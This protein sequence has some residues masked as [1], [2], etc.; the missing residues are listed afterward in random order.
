MEPEV[1]QRTIFANG[2]IGCQFCKKAC[3]PFRGAI[4]HHELKCRDNAEKIVPQR[5]KPKREGVDTQE[6]DF[7]SLF[8]FLA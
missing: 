4:V 2:L 7:L 3:S 8:S 5:T 1:R 6:V